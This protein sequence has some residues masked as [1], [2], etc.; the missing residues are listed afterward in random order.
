MRF[1]TPR[2]PF[3]RRLRW[4][5]GWPA[6]VILVLLLAACGGDP[7]PT[8]TPT[9][10]PTPVA[11]ATPTSSPTPA[12]TDTPTP[13]PTPVATATPTPTDTPVPT[14]T[15][16]PTPTPDANVMDP[17]RDP[18]LSPF[19][20]L[21]LDP[22]V[23]QRRP[24]AI[25]ISNDEIAHE[26][27][28]DLNKADIIVESRVEFNYTRYTALYHSQDA[29]RVGTIRS[30]RLID[31]DLPV[32]F[33][34]VLCFSGAV[35][36]VRDQLYNSDLRDQLIEQAINGPSF[37]RDT[38]WP[39]PN[40][41]FADTRVLRQTAESRGWNTPPQPTLR[42][43]FSVAPPPGGSPASALTVP[44]PVLPV[45]WQY[46]P[47]R[48]RWL[49]WAGGQPHIDKGSGEQVI[50]DNI[51][52]LGINHVVTLIIE[53][54]TQR[55]GEGQNCRNCSIE[56]QIWGEGP[57][58]IFRDG[59]VYEGKWVRPERYAPFRFVDAAGNDIP[60]KPGTSWWQVTP[61]DM[62]V[63]VQP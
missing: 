33:D 30:A 4:L 63:T 22:A 59:R 35:K 58:K 39:P 46:D 42:T 50:A 54:G 1:L 6:L 52:V 28:S 45:R 11:T 20:G 36:D 49:R 15:P 44:Y 61:L 40:N 14:D 38:T 5:W 8:P 17:A 57:L 12:V 55:M 60:L 53:H 51:V 16:T 43:V 41:L 29:A 37:Y 31:R 24:L 23:R 32:I 3:P 10:T 27:Q 34:A 25:K 62:T 56:I 48:G 21:P 47:G 18:N 26:R 9:R 19:T 2:L 7:P 13:L